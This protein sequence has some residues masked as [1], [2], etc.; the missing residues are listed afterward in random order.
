MEVH[1]VITTAPQN[2]F[3]DDLPTHILELILN[4]LTDVNDLL[5]ASVVCTSWHRVVQEGMWPGLKHLRVLGWTPE[6]S[7]G[8]EWTSSRCRNLEEVELSGCAGL[9][10]AELAPLGGVPLRSLKLAGCWRFEGYDLLA[11]INAHGCLQDVDLSGTAI[12]ID[13]LTEAFAP[14]F[15]APHCSE[16]ASGS[17]TGVTRL[18]LRNIG[19]DNEYALRSFPWIGSALRHLD[20][21]GNNWLATHHAYGLLGANNGTRAAID[22]DGQ[23]PQLP[24]TA[25]EPW[26]SGGPSGSTTP[27]SMNVT[28]LQSLNLSDCPRLQSLPCVEALTMLRQLDVCRTAI[29]GGCLVSIAKRCRHLRSLAVSG[30]TNLTGSGL[31]TAAFHLRL[32]RLEADN[33]PGAGDGVAAVIANM[34]L[35]SAETDDPGS[36]SCLFEVSAAGGGLTDATLSEVAQYLQTLASYGSPAAAVPELQKGIAAI[37]LQSATTGS[38]SQPSDKDTRACTPSDAVLVQ[39][40]T[41]SGF[42]VFRVPGC[43][44]LGKKGLQHLASVGAFAGLREMDVSHL[45]SLWSKPAG[46]LCNIAASSAGRLRVLAANECTMSLAILSAIGHHCSELRTLSLVGCRGICNAG[47]AAI[48]TG[49]PKLTDVAVGGGSAVLWSEDCALPGF[50]AMRS[51]R[52]ARRNQLQD[53]RLVAALQ[54]LPRLKSLVLAGC[55][56][57]TDRSLQALP[58]GLTSLHLSTCER[59]QG[60]PL[61]QLTNLQS[62]RLSGCPAITQTAVQAASISCEKL[63]VLELPSAMDVACVPTRA[64][65][66]SG[67]LRGLK[68]EGG[69]RS[70]SHWLRRRSPAAIAAAAI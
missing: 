62:L 4:Q 70:N 9:L 69:R 38:P 18:R 51:L 10:E 15:A 20:I 37:S 40:P 45:Q 56:D 48:S 11:A 55:A 34:P 32:S 36:A 64:P 1:S 28:A 60:A 46:V 22:F 43:P 14:S 50:T 26:R 5:G 31:E 39:S 67:H 2:L 13:M 61:S 8:I 47:L 59:L 6:V 68:I 30:C 53:V 44:R 52:L 42:A 23:L 16:G 63:R 17:S 24:M 29:S 65:P 35:R 41:V 58:Q 19:I 3:M 27:V 54:Q 49:C 25:A 7:A 12:H 57:I 21:S 33:L 66:H